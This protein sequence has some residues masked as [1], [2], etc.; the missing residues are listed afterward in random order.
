MDA[1]R[2]AVARSGA[3]GFAAVRDDELADAVV[4]LTGLVHQ[5]ESLRPELLAEAE[6]REVAQ[7]EAASGTDAWAAALTGEKRAL[8]GGGLWLAER[9]ASR[10]PA[11]R[12]AFADGRLGLEQAMVIVRAADQAPPEATAEQLQRAEELMVAKAT[13]DANR[14]GRPMGVARLRQA[15]RRMFATIDRDLAD[16]HEAAMLGRQEARAE[17]ETWLTM[18]DD[19][20]GTYT[21]KFCIPE[22]HGRLLRDALQRLSAPRRLGRDASGAQVVDPS[23]P[24]TASG[25]SLHEAHGTAFCELVEHLPRDG[26]SANGATLLVTIDLE[27]LR[28]GLGSARLDTGTRISAG[29]ARR[30]AC[31][32]QLVPIVLGRGSQP[33]D[34][35][36]ADRLFTPAQRRALAAVH[37][38]CGIE[39]CERPFAW[40]EIHHRRPWAHGGRTDL[41]DA[42]P[43]CGHH[44]RR[45]HDE[46]FDLRQL[47]G[48]GW[49]LHPRR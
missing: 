3:R 20:N 23:A 41:T 34:V 29:E 45:A 2:S 11:T 25:V 49:R 42:V 9:L 4:G 17:A 33:L 12:E 40:C 48:G 21:G 37:D 1:A 27:R 44:H 46:R 6:R 10:Y 14:G 47:P 31:A 30:L 8:L 32:A 26:W 28:D 7:R 5:A 39:T 38:S 13:G 36:R 19:G 43:L 24:G 22:L 35:G 18:G 15:A 16:R